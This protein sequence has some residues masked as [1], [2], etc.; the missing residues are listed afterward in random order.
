[1]IM[2]YGSLLG[3]ALISISL[4]AIAPL[5][6]QTQN[7]D[8][9]STPN[10]TASPKQ[11]DYILVVQQGQTFAELIRQAELQ[12]TNLVEH[13]FAADPNI[14]EIGINIVGDRAGQQA[15][16]LQAKV[17]RADWQQQPT[18][19]QWTKYFATSAVLLGFNNPEK[20]PSAAPEN[21]TTPR[22]QPINSPPPLSNSTVQPSSAP[23]PST[24]SQSNSPTSPNPS[25]PSGGASL[26]ESDPGY[27]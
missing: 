14:V 15:P 21:P 25:Q 7:I 1:M 10:Q 13:E 16:L 26:E 4:G 20:T 19:R 23:A 24:P 18:I 5:W 11:I 17:S 27:R 8:S 3:A 9:N 6:A 22:Q 2:R 12:A